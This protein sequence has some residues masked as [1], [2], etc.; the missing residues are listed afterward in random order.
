MPFT[1]DDLKRLK[2]E[3]EPYVEGD[4]RILTGRDWLGLIARLESAETDAWF[5][6][7]YKA[8]RK[9]D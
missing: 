8:G 7:E 2:D 9:N 5:W 3:F 4:P 1:D 6:R